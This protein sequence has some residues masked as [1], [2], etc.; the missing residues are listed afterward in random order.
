MKVL[1]LDDRLN[2][3]STNESIFFFIFKPRFELSVEKK[4]LEVL[5]RFV[6]LFAL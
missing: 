6:S 3:Q 2:D 5:L 1:V 4:I